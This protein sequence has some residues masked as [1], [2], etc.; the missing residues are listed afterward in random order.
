MLLAIDTATQVMSLAL[1]D[2]NSLRA[3]VTWHTANNHTAELAPAVRDLLARCGI[4]ARDLTALGV[5]VGPGAYTALRIGVALAKGLAAACSLP[6]VGVSS[7]D[8]L[9]AAQPYAQGCG[10]V[11]VV[12]AGRGRVVAATYRWRRGRWDNRGEPEVLDWDTL[13]ASIDGPAAISGEISAAGQARLAEAQAR[14]VPI[15]I[16]PPVYR[17]RRAGFLAEEALAR[18]RAGGDYDPTRLVPLYVKTRDLP[19]NT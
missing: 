9:A 2:G 4:T 15:T 10:L 1:H 17:L 11:V 8:T 3:E 14:G 12:E 7:L 18:L 19:G 13:I 5:S 16:N 6:L